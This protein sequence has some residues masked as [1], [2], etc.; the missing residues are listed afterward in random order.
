MENS[1]V[2]RMM[3]LTSRSRLAIVKKTALIQNGYA[4]AD[5]LEIRLMVKTD[6]K[7]EGVID[8]ESLSKIKHYDS[9]EICDGFLF[10]KTGNA[11]SKFPVAGP[12][13]EFPKEPEIDK[14]IGNL[15]D[16]ESMA[17]HSLA[18]IVSDEEIRPVLT[19]VYI[20]VDHIVATDTHR[21]RWLPKTTQVANIIIPGRAALL[22]TPESYNVSITENNSHA[23]FEGEHETIFTRLIE[24]MYPQ[25]QNVI[26]TDN[27]VCIKV[28]TA[29]LI[30]V[31][32]RA[33][34][35]DTENHTCL[36]KATPGKLTISAKNID[37]NTEFSDGIL[38]KLSGAKQFPIAFNGKFMLSMLDKS[39]DKTVIELS[40]P[41][42]AAIINGNSLLMPV[43]FDERLEPDYSSEAQTEEDNQEKETP[44]LQNSEIGENI[45]TLGAEMIIP[46]EETTDI[47]APQPDSVIDDLPDLIT[48]ID[49][50]TEKSFGIVGMVEII[51]PEFLSKY[52]SKCKI[53]VNNVR[54]DGYLFSKKRREQFSQLMDEIGLSFMITHVN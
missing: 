25:Y 8:L 46:D 6:I 17:I 11:T 15:C 16:T 48:V 2:K 9:A 7:G 43:M 50:V 3:K 18:P 47:P 33:L 44:I 53:S 21:L 14:C 24:G 27:P 38:A 37:L 1:N 32:Q 31:I 30:E 12:V 49:S 10:I 40:M 51:P 45:E 41:N 35:A 28:K 23:K 19:G 34:L 39:I 54:R 22:L 29:E 42:K 4:I 5:D 52:G 36:F 26:P 13:D 20:G